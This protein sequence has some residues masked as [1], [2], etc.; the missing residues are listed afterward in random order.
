MKILVIQK[1]RIG[2]VLTST[3]LLEAI[4]EKY[5]ESEIHYLIYPNSLAVVEH[6]PFL[7]KIVILDDVT[8]RSKT[9]FISFLFK[10]R[11]EKYDVVVDAY[12]KPNSVLIGWFSGAK[13]TITFNKSYS[14]I[15]YT[16][17]INRKQKPDTNATLAIEHR[18]QLLEPLDIEF[19]EYKPKLF[20]LPSEIDFAKET[21]KQKGINL[22]KP[23]VMISAIGSKETKTY[24][25]PY[26]AEVLDKIAEYKD[27]QILFNYIPNQ[28]EIAFELMQLCKTETQQ[29]IFFDVYE[30]DLRKFIAITS[31]CKALIGN[32]GGATHMAKALSVPTFIIFAIDVQKIGWSIYENETTDIAVHVH[33]YIPENK[34]D[35]DELRIQFKP[36]LFAGKLDTFLNFNI[37]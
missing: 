27:V 15:F 31:L 30:N 33:D 37:K 35:F 16:N 14:R 8:K 23:I 10:I 22:D 13:K 29:K 25:L 24:L 28:K 9:K 5:P 32:E 4:R 26:M 21:L 6:N 7:N 3:I 34:L 20:L 12:G 19:K 18:M 36:L 1:K 2:D 17:I 11:K